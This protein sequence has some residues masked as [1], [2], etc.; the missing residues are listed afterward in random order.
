MHSYSS[1]KDVKI[2]TKH[3]QRHVT[4]PWTVEAMNKDNSACGQGHGEVQTL[5]WR[6]WGFNMVQPLWKTVWRFP[7]EPHTAQ[8]FPARPLP[9]GTGRAH[10]HM[11]R[12]IQ[13]P[14]TQTGSNPD[15]P[16]QGKGDADH[17]H[18]YD[19]SPPPMVRSD[20]LLARMM[21]RVALPGTMLRDGSIPCLPRYYLF[22]DS[23]YTKFWRTH[24]NL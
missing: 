5:A 13:S 24:M 20:K 19:A 10:P 3:I 4:A 9:R 21:A 6:C 14:K 11:G 16:Q 12:A 17:V 15:V 8:Q 18:P 23:I 2:A 22:C 7:K 1:K